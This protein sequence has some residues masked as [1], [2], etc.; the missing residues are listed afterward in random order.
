MTRQER[1]GPAIASAQIERRKV[2]ELVADRL[3]G[4]ITAG[5][6]KPGDQ[7]PPERELTEMLGVGRSSVREA[8]R[9]LESKGL[10]ESRSK[11]SLVVA[12]RKNPLND[13]LEL[14]LALDKANAHELYELRR[15]LESE[16]AALAAEHRRDDQ[17]ERLDQA[18]DEM[19]HALT[20]SSLDRYIKADLRFHLIIA[21]A[22][23]NRLLLH[24]MEAIRDVLQRV[25]SSIYLIPGS[26]ENSIAEHRAIRAAI[27]AKNQATAS[28]AMCKH[29]VRVEDDVR[30]SMPAEARHGIMAG[31]ELQT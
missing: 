8:L 12:E 3:I 24:S 9:L 16:A 19:E 2:Y 28:A 25:L 31:A 30:R 17:L 21:E 10:I 4:E 11:G 15:I 27:G 5:R 14:L 23:G 7:M 6:L 22:T 20:T 18:I 26:P 1:P 29:L 13:S